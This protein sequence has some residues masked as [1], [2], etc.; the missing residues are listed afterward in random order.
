MKTLYFLGEDGG[1]RVRPTSIGNK[2][3]WTH[4]Y[5]SHGMREVSKD[6]YDAAKKRFG[7]TDTE[8]AEDQNASQE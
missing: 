3:M 5:L 2:N 8:S 4:W 7:D 1:A 6:E